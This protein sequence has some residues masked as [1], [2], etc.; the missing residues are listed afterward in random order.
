MCT[1]RVYKKN[2]SDR[3]N[4]NGCNTMKHQLLNLISL[5]TRSHFGRI[6]QPI[7]KQNWIRSF[8][9]HDRL[10]D[11]WVLAKQWHKVVGNLSPNNSS[12][13]H[14]VAQVT[15]NSAAQQTAVYLRYDAVR[16]DTNTI[17][18]ECF[19]VR[20]LKTVTSQLNLSVFIPKARDSLITPPHTA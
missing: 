13:R 18:Y 2:N 5:Y 20:V 16:Q 7:L 10:S 14:H 1:R 11:D 15:N 17:R 9:D 6:T 4:T 12:A 3:G 19:N 8:T